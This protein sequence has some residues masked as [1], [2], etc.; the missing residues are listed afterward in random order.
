MLIK[1]RYEVREIIGSG[2]MGRVYRAFD[3]EMGREVAIKSLADMDNAKALQL[4]RREWRMIANLNHA[5]VIEIYD[6]GEYEENG[7]SR[8]FFVMPLLRGQTLAQILA[9][10]NAPLPVEKVVDLAIRVAEGL[11]AIHELQLVHRDIKPSNI[12][13]LN[14][15]SVKLID[16]GIAQ[17]AGGTTGLVIGTE[18]YMSPEQTMGSQCSASSDLFSLAVV[19]YESLTQKKPFSGPDQTEVFRQIREGIATPVHVLNPA[20]P[21]AVSKV[22]AKSMA[23]RP[24]HRWASASEFAQM[25]SRALRN[26][27]IEALDP[28]RI[29]TRVQRAREAFDLENYELARD[30]L[31]DIEEA[32]F[33][34]PQVGPLRHKADEAI[35][36]REIGKR[37]SSAQRGIDYEEYDLAL[38]EIQWILR[39][40]PTHMK[41][42]EL[43]QVVEEKITQRRLNEHLMR[44]KRELE[45]HDYPRARQSLEMVLA[46]EPKHA[47][48]LGLLQHLELREE[49]YKS[50]RR[51]KDELYKAG[52]EAFD[53]REFA[54]AIGM[55]RRVLEL[56]NEAP[57]TGSGSGANFRDFLAEA[58]RAYA[59][60]ERYRFE[61]HGHLAAGAFDKAFGT[62]KQAIAA[63]PGHPLFVGLAA[64]AEEGMARVK[65]LRFGQLMQYAEHEQDLERRLAVLQAAAKEFPNNREIEQWT[66]K[67][68]DRL[69]A[70]RDVVAKSKLRAD[71]GHT[72][73][74][75]ERLA[76]LQDIYPAGQPNHAPAQAEATR[77]MPVPKAMAAVA[78]AAV[79][80]GVAESPSMLSRGSGMG[81]PLGATSVMPIPVVAPAPSPERRGPAAEAVAAPIKSPAAPATAPA[82]AQNAAEQKNEA[83]PPAKP[84]VTPPSQPK[85][86][87]SGPPWTTYA[88]VIFTA[89][90]IGGSIYAWRR[91]ADSTVVKTQ[92]ANAGEASGTVRLQGLAAGATL[93]IDGKPVSAGDG[94][95]IQLSAGEHTIVVSRAGFEPFSGRV[96]VGAGAKGVAFPV[97]AMAALPARLLISADWDGAQVK[98][99]EQNL[100]AVTGKRLE[101]ELPA[102]T[103]NI[104]IAKDGAV[105]KVSVEVSPGAMPKIVNVA[106]GQ[107][108]IAAANL[109]EESELWTNVNGMRTAEGEV[110]D[111]TAAMKI[112]GPRGLQ[113][114]DGANVVTN[115]VAQNNAFPS[116][117]IHL[118]F[119]SRI[120]ALRL[121]ANQEGFGVILDGAAAKYPVVKGC[122]LLQGLSAGE[123]TIVPTKEGFE[124]ERKQV[125]VKA[126]E[127]VALN[128]ELREVPKSAALRF[129]NALAGTEIRIDGQTA[130]RA[131]AAGTFEIA[132]VGLGSHRVDIVN[133]PRYKARMG[134]TVAPNGRVFEPVD[135]KLDL[136]PVN[137]EIQAPPDS[138][139]RWRC[140]PDGGSEAKSKG[141]V[142]ADCPEGPLTV[143]VAKEGFENFEGSFSTAGKGG[144]VFP[145]AVAMREKKSSAKAQSGCGVEELATV[146]FVRDGGSFRAARAT[147]LPCAGLAGKY[148]FTL[149]PAKGP[150][151][152]VKRIGWGVGNVKFA[153][154]DK[155]F[156][157]PAGTTEVALDKVEEIEV[158]L[159]IAGKSLRQSVSIGGKALPPYAGSLEG[160]AASMKVSVEKDVR[161][162][163]LAFVE[164]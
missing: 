29:Q 43:K 46:T 47:E 142:K 120:G 131:S 79:S 93:E 152:G 15:G 62:A 128:V 81:D 59:T 50:A 119:N 140:G 31:R 57:E 163:R 78:G 68:Q 17:L 129:L 86:P 98:L 96:N 90:L 61:I 38:D 150:F 73:Q 148:T 32:G 24:Q 19:C 67:L 109:G 87:S 4:F 95:E 63:F 91:S 55:L 100:G 156:L 9:L 137:V 58:E 159:T 138:A 54:T 1:G 8:P 65:V 53:A 101:A 160:D 10:S 36:Q 130:G 75:E 39:N 5:N 76:Y 12:F 71:Q 126:R 103:H 33:V 153:F 132:A 117:T 89:V 154:A 82:A 121:C 11:Q 107:N 74:A 94:A 112:R 141:A 124:G 151:G 85:G 64:T 161:I 157:S 23:K 69:A 13:V 20:V 44:A 125:T 6:S 27:A 108:T 45:G 144:T 92:S 34:D 116:L 72:A 66:Q 158:E 146:G 104:L 88:L 70:V 56:E 164:Q 16:F 134:V 3:R 80:G 40:S 162:G 105:A 123:H 149:R 127:T 22:I 18:S 14:N 51:E 115:L 97:P 26:E 145:V 84:K 37:L 133:A 136:L 135:A 2:G 77:Q 122:M 41:A 102:G 110:L 114:L 48:A 99:D 83:Q 21:P 52:R 25:L 60:V 147:A 7:S 49:S 139:V 143:S 30:V 113:F 118:F 111:K 42:L 35:Q 106:A 28:N 155:K